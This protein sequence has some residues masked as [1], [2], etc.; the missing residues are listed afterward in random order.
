MIAA[1]NRF[2]FGDGEP[3]W[4]PMG[5][6]RMLAVAIYAWFRLR[7]ELWEME[8]ARDVPY[9]L[10]PDNF[11]L[12]LLPL[13]Y[14]LGDPQADV[15]KV[16]LA[17]ACVFGFVG[18]LTRP[19]M[20]VL[21]VGA[22]WLSSGYSSLQ[23]FNHE[24][25][26]TL[27]FFW[28]LAVYPSGRSFSVDAAIRWWRKG[29]AEGRP[30]GEI[31]S[32]KSVG[33][34]GYKL[35]LVTLAVV[36]ITAGVSKLRYSDGDWHNG[37]TLAFYMSRT[38]AQQL[39]LGATWERLVDEPWKSPVPLVDHGYGGSATEL[40]QSMARSP[41][42]M[43]ITAL[44]TLVLELGAFLMLGPAWIAAAFMA[45]VFVMHSTIGATMGLGFVTYRMY[46]LLLVDWPGLAATLRRLRGGD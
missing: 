8:V 3:S 13:Q 18:F 35:A 38:D 40:S 7:R 16:T 32:M 17:L 1:W 15:L 27:A 29:R 20:L 9:A 4:D 19:A 26:L 33:P 28:I 39:Y 42:I 14:P 5:P 45:S 36:Y 25:V 43:R 24:L 6:V 21:A 12:G 30:F 46:L 34:W 44:A 22:T 10:V 31:F 41:L 37:E 2:W 23:Y 11:G